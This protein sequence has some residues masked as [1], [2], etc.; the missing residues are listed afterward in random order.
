MLNFANLAA[1]DERDEFVPLSVRQPDGIGV[2]PDCYG[3]VGDHDFGAFCAEWAQA[4]FLRFQLT[5]LLLTVSGDN[6]HGRRYRFD[7]PRGTVRRCF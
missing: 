7:L 1:L 4:K 3:F 6:P 5:V 2:L